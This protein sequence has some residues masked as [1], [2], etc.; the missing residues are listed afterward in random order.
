MYCLKIGNNLKGENQS[1]G[2]SLFIMGK[3]D[4]VLKQFSFRTVFS[5][6]VSEPRYYC[7]LKDTHYMALKEKKRQ[8]IDS[9]YGIDFIVLTL[10]KSCEEL[11]INS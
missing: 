2:F 4:S 1:I 10:K 9:K 7:I 8:Y 3:I 11:P 5:N 6:G